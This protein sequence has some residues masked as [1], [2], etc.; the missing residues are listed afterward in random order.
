MVKIAESVLNI[1]RITF[2]LIWTAFCG[3]LGIVLMLLTW[4]SGW[5]LLFLGNILW[6]PLVCAVCGIKVIV[7]GRENIKKRSG[8][9]YIANHSSLLDIAVLVKTIPLPLYFVA[10]NELKKV[11]VLGQYMAVLGHIFVDRKNKDKAMQSMRIAAKK[12]ND[13]KNVITFP[14]GTRS[15]DG[16]IQTFK[17]GTFVIAKEGK[18]DIIPIG[19]SGAF[20][21]LPSGRSQIKSGKVFVHIGKKMDS[22][23]FATM[24]IEEIASEAQ[25]RVQTLLTN[26]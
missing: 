11:P 12:I 5:I 13:G 25:K 7:T 3:I 8:N 2:I 14:E 16:K 17:K 18:I 15:K 23:S 21:V 19:I 20:D 6:G 1:L 24:S 9:I 26:R 10:K 4:H 22:E